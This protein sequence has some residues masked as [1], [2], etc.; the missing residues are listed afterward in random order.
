ML[1]LVAA[2]PMQWAIGVM[3][4]GFMRSLCWKHVSLDVVVVV[5]GFVVV[6]WCLLFVFVF[7]GSS[8]V[9]PDQSNKH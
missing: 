9:Q 6:V 2:R 8:I 7:E 4:P 1:V 5:V 3:S